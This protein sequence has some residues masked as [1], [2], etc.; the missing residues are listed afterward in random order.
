MGLTPEGHMS[1]MWTV[2]LEHEDGS[3]GTVEL[4]DTHYTAENVHAL[5]SDQANTVRAV[6]H[7]PHGQQD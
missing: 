7:L 1:K 2:H 6:A 3:R 4:P 5:A